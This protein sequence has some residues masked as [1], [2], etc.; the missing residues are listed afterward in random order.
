MNPKDS[1]PL[2]PPLLSSPSALLGCNC[3]S[4]CYSQYFCLLT[5]TQ[6]KKKSLI[7]DLKNLIFTSIR[8]KKYRNVSAAKKN[9]LWNKTKIS[10]KKCFGISDL[11]SGFIILSDKLSL[12]MNFVTL[13]IHDYRMCLECRGQKSISDEKENTHNIFQCLKF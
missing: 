11:H 10:Y 9:I 5:T 4:Q 13:M 2:L 8:D 12:P 6:K 3:I 7:I 1:Q